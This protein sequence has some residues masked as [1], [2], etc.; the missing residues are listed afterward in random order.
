MIGLVIHKCRANK[1]EQQKNYKHTFLLVNK[2]KEPVP[3]SLFVTSNS[4][5]ASLKKFHNFHPPKIALPGKAEKNMSHSPMTQTL[6]SA[7]S[8]ARAHGVLEGPQRG[9]SRPA[10]AGRRPVCDRPA[11]N[12]FIFQ[13]KIPSDH[14]PSPPTPTHRPTHSLTVAN[15][16]TS[17]H[18]L[19]F[20]RDSHTHN[21]RHTSTQGTGPPIGL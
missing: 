5:T 14:T 2:L 4:R 7:R 16:P 11:S 9:G 17:P 13:L 20:G 3:P 19:P 15:R 6:P 18:C 21:P 1:T 10:N 8:R 12:N